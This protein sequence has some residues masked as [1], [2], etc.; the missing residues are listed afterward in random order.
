MKKIAIGKALVLGV[1]VIPLAGADE[2]FDA[3]Q[4]EFQQASQ[5]WGAKLDE[6][7]GEDG[8]IDWSK[9]PKHPTADFAPRFKT[10]ADEHL[11]QG[12]A[13]PALCWLINRAGREKIGDSDQPVGKWALEMLGRHHA[14]DAAIA[15]ELP[16]LR[17]ASYTVG[18]EPL[19]V[20]FKQVIADNNELDA[21]AWSTF[22]LGFLH[23]QDGRN[24]GRC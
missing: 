11:E 4:K 16:R 2:D 23:Y 15:K 8:N 6:F 13:L 5:D 17:Y 12:A 22:N 10:Y 19:I 9:T 7:K 20:F 1:L 21:K 24:P 3:L 18:S 14:G